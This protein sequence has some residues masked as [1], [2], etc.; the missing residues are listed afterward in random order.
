[1]YGPNQKTH[2][3]F[4]IE[5]YCGVGLKKDLYGFDQLYRHLHACMLLSISATS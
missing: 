1:M 3:R 2:L 4:L 5:A